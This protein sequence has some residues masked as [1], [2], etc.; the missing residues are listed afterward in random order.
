MPIEK[1][2]GAGSKK[3]TKVK[4]D[5]IAIETPST[6]NDIKPAA[7]VIID[8]VQQEEPFE[9]DTT[10]TVRDGHGDGSADTDGHGEAGEME[11]A[12][13]GDAAEKC[14]DVGTGASDGKRS[15]NGDGGR[16]VDVGHASNGHD[17]D[18]KGDRRGDRKRDSKGN[19]VK[20]IYIIRGS[21]KRRGGLSK[22]RRNADPDSSSESSDSDSDSS[23]SDD[24]ELE[25]EIKRCRKR[26]ALKKSRVR[27]VK[28]RKKPE[29]EPEPE[30]E[31][32]SESESD[33]GEDEPEQPSKPAYRMPVFR[34]I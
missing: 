17:E 9:P 31:T 20:K 8:T 28:K 13:V 32:Q 21:D 26:N 30:P 12:V 3:S 23:S 14:I 19:V 11:P 1:K 27:D 29:P 33:S 18:A 24:S 25:R 22:R 6:K 10:D 4:I 5:P 16:V 2:R 34:F 15:A 7:P